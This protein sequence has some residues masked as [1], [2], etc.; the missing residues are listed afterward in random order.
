MQSSPD[1][2]RS[3]AKIPLETLGMTLLES[4][5]LSALLMI[6]AA[7][8]QGRNEASTW[9]GGKVHSPDSFGELIFALE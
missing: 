8:P 9:G 6:T 3:V 1:G 5:K 2:W 7:N 4:N